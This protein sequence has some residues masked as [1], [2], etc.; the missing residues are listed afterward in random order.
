M[1]PADPTSRSSASTSRTSGCATRP[2]GRRTCSRPPLARSDR[3]GTQSRSCP[4]VPG[5]STENSAYEGPRA[6]SIAA[7]AD[8]IGSASMDDLLDLVHGYR[9]ERAWSLGLARALEATGRRE[10]GAAAVWHVRGC[11]RD[12]LE[13]LLADDAIRAIYDDEFVGQVVSDRLADLARGIVL[14]DVLTADPRLRVVLEWDAVMGRRPGRREM[15][16][17]WPT[18]RAARRV[19]PPGGRASRTPLGGSWACWRR[20]ST[21]RPR[22]PCSPRARRSPSSSSGSAWPPQWSP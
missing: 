22:P 14:L 5:R 19:W 20:A 10:R 1:R 16:P 6:E 11:V 18:R 21:P 7:L 15:S 2:S 4:T 17:D 13:A 3:A 9:P 8:R 12:R